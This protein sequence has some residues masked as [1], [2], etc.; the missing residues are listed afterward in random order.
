MKTIIHKLSLPFFIQSTQWSV[1]T[2]K[3]TK[4]FLKLI[5]VWSILLPQ[6]L[7]QSCYH[8][9]VE[10]IISK[11]SL[12]KLSLFNRQLTGDTTAVI[13]S[14]VH[15]I[16]SRY[17]KS[18]GNKLAAQYIYERLVS[19]G[20]NAEYW[21]YSQTGTNIL[22]IKPGNKYPNQKI[23]LCAHY[24]DIV[25]G[26][27]PDTTHGADDNASGTSA[28]LEAARILIDYDLPYTIVFAAWDEEEIG[29]FGSDAY[30]DSCKSRG[31]SIV[32]VI[33]F[34]MLGWDG[35]D[36][37]KLIIGTDSNSVFLANLLISSANIYEP[38]LN[39]RRS[40]SGSDD[41]S[42][43]KRGYK[44]ILVTEDYPDFNPYYHT[45]GDNFLHL[46]KP[47]F[48]KLTKAAIAGLLVLQKDYVIS[49]DHT[50]LGNTDDTSGRIA[51][52][53]ISS[54]HG[55][56][57]GYNSPRLYFKTGN[58]SY[59]VLQSYYNNQDTFR[60][61]IPGQPVRSLVSYYIAAQDSKNTI[62]GSLP[63]G[64]RG[65][66]PPGNVAPANTFS[67]IVFDQINECSKTLPRQLPPRSF[68][69]DSITMFRNGNILDI[70]VSLSINH[71]ND[72]DLFI[73]LSRAGYSIIAL[74]R[75]NGGE[76][77]NYIYT[78]FD[79]EAQISIKE[80]TPP[81]TGSFR[82]E[83]Q[84]S[85]FDNSEMQGVWKLRILNLSSVITGEL[86]NWCINFQYSVPISVQNNQVPVTMGLSQN[87]PNPYNSSTSISYSL[88]READV[89]IVIF[90]I[91]GREVKTLLS[92]KLTAGEYHISFNANDMASGLYFY[93]MFLEGVL[94]ETK[95][96]VLLK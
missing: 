17:W 83:Q 76:G 80:G 86:V 62:I 70:D 3:F 11:I 22:A 91:L 52:V 82:P 28:V 39:P 68:V 84:L 38:S 29:L 65:L 77:D 69:Y 42:F 95:K 32:A 75:Q 21:V 74:S 88:S 59:N 54:N 6:L 37:G 71:T 46:N 51:E 40:N 13:G 56:A 53:V 18:D 9:E 4:F 12:E 14:E 10:T 72:S 85:V 89:R 20:Y 2:V 73:W 93:S 16:I 92:R 79:D 49:F 7:S 34:D 87:F 36:D 8:P 60:F 48:L 23:I 43:Q 96:M 63:A 35:N 58:G 67:Y 25:N 47:Y 94:F 66:N 55:I 64:A 44:S 78:T 15:T 90:D 33:N 5:V 26:I 45:V 50:P 27:V 30:A 57:S 81:F 41:R 61:L 1:L 31:D 19:F 24:D